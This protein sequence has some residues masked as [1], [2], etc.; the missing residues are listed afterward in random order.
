[1]P[2]STDCSMQACAPQV[3]S[4]APP[5]LDKSVITPEGPYLLAPHHA[6][7]MDL[8]DANNPGAPIGADPIHPTPESASDPATS[9]LSDPM[10]QPASIVR[11]VS[12]AAGVSPPGACLEGDSRG[13]SVSFCCASFF[14]SHTIGS[15]TT[16][17]G[18]FGAFREFFLPSTT[19]GSDTSTK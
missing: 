9:M 16:G 6:L 17:S 15:N 1:V 12:P 11:A 13:S 3:P 14:T 18:D 5:M 7:V 4:G 2:I 19:K 8:V 10:H